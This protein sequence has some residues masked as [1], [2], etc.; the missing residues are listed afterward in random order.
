MLSQC[1]K[2][3]GWD[4]S[5]I[6][7]YSIFGHESKAQSSVFG[8]ANDPT[9]AFADS[10]AVAGRAGFW[11]A[12]FGHAYLYL[13]QP[14]ASSRNYHEFPADI[15]ATLV[16]TATGKRRAQTASNS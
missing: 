3:F 14:M 2:I 11:L 15:C 6:V 8:S 12:E 13:P 16:E 4:N 1:L 10:D 5:G 7:D 9:A